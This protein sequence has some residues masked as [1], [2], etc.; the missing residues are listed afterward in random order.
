MSHEVTG[1]GNSRLVHTSD[2]CGPNDISDEYITQWPSRV[3]KEVDWLVTHFVNRFRYIFLKDKFCIFI[4]I[5]LECDCKGPI[6]YKSS[7]V[8]VLAWHQMYGTV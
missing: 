6:D 2:R 1:L 3:L 4:Q 8:Q 5:S 7:L